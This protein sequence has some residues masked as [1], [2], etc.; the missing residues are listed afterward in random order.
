MAETIRISAEQLKAAMERGALNLNN[1]FTLHPDFAGKYTVEKVH[2]YKYQRAEDP[3]GFRVEMVDPQGKTRFIPD[4]HIMR[5]LLVAQKPAKMSVRVG[6]KPVE[7]VGYREDFDELLQGANTLGGEVGEYGDDG[8]LIG[9][10]LPK[11]I[12]I[13]GAVTPKV[14]EGSKSHPSIPL[15]FYKGYRQV[16]A[17]HQEQMKDTNSFITRDEFQAYLEANAAGNIEIKGVSKDLKELTL[18]NPKVVENMRNW[19]HTLLIKDVREETQQTPP[20][21][22]EEKPKTTRGRKATSK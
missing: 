13:V 10:N 9:A 20:P 4:Y 19:N 21:A 15:R 17:Y 12:E 6:S 5:S 11:H 8:D 18:S 14:T 16:L 7:N 22:D 3:N 2:D 1:N